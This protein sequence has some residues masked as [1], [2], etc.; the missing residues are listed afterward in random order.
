MLVFR[1]FMFSFEVTG[2]WAM[3]VDTLS[4]NLILARF[5]IGFLND[6]LRFQTLFYTV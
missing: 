3:F 6:E 1:C 2:F 4:A 5:C